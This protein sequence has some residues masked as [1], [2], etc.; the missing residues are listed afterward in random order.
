[1]KQWEYRSVRI[2]Y[3]GEPEEEY[4]TLDM[5]GVNGWEMVGFSIDWDAT[6]CVGPA[7]FKRPVPVESGG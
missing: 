4:L 6:P 1:M 7:I 2:N 5:L 3:E